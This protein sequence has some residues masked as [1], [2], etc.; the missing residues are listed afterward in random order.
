MHLSSQI[1]DTVLMIRP[2]AFGYNEETAA[3]NH[4]QKKPAEASDSLQHRAIIE[5][6]RMAETLTGAGINVIIIEDSAEPKKP[7]A[8]FPNNW[9]NA[10][11]GKINVFPMFAG[12][13]RDEKRNDILE[14]LSNMYQVHDVRDWSEFEAEAMYL[15][16]T[17]SMVIDHQNRV[18]YACLSARTHRSVVE[19][20]AASSDFRVITFHAFDSKEREIYHTNVMMS[21]GDGFAVLC[22]KAIAD[23]VERVAVAQL[24]ENTGHENIYISPEQMEAFAG[25]LLHLKNTRGEK[26]IVLSQ[27]AMNVFT[28]DQKSRLSKYGELLPIDV[29]TIEDV[30]G[31]SVRCM[32]A[33]IFLERRSNS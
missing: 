26:F 21:I 29:S 31:G 19:K 6:D 24:L 30:E 4:F 20:F 2:A 5:F 27:R 15:E 14:H 32:M 11:D 23:D 7:D 16:G 3:N 28:D 33:E 8:V 18:I 9:F 1:T 13:R 22:P 17:G 10:C 12:T 25:N